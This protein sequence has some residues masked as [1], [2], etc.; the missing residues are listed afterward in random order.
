MQD[1]VHQQYHHEYCQKQHLRQYYSSFQQIWCANN[2]G[3]SVQFIIVIN[4]DKCG[5]EGNYIQYYLISPIKK[6]P[7]NSRGCPF[8]NATFWGPR[9]CEVAIIWSWYITNCWWFT[10]ARQGKLTWKPLA[11]F[12]AL[13]T[14]W[15]KCRFATPIPSIYGI[16]TYIWL[17]L[18]VKPGKCRYIYDT[19]MLWD[20]GC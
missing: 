20:T 8:L 6:F 11:M 9:S 13:L 17:F 15:W 19:W 12:K 10:L 4:N 3:Q 14:N 16:F 18:K 1:F 2:T 5:H 7:W